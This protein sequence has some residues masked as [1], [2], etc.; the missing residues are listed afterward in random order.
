MKVVVAIDS[1]KGSLSSLQAGNAIKEG[2]LR[3][4]ESHV[5]VKPLA[6]GG[7]GTME[8]LIDGLGGEYISLEVLDQMGDPMV[9]TYG[10]LKD[11]NT[12]I[13]EMAR[14]VG[15]TLINEQTRNP[16]LA[17]TYAVGQLI[18]DAI[19]KGCLNFII[20]IGGSATNDGGIG[21]LSALGVIFSDKN[22]K[23]LECTPM[24]LGSIQS[25]DTTKMH[26]E[27]SNCKFLVACDVNNP[28]CGE[29]GATYI[30]GPQKGVKID[31]L[32]KLDANMLHYATITSD[33]L[34][35][36]HINSSGSG[37]AG[38]I[39]FALLSYLDATIKSGAEVVIDAL[40]LEKDIKTADI[41][42]TGEGRLDYQTAMGKGPIS[43]A[44]ISKKYNKPVIA[45]AGSIS[46]T[47]NVCNQSGIDSYFSIL[48][49]VT[50][51]KDAMSIEIATKNM[52]D[53]T[54]QIFRLIKSLGYGGKH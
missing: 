47:A 34:G 33:T 6:D 23:Y 24:S 27:I 52:I 53:S 10:I 13:I 22:G 39:G 21:M 42:I 8:T 40:D 7:E 28:L 9:G 18:L 25:I 15:I 31:E 11:S 14:V 3:A 49:T 4:I 20:C 30:Y 2:I 5:I 37:A 46:E 50:T 1:F 19:N 43:V 51:L 48:N 29:N 35:N 36:C 38:G 45:L 17:N 26:K 32:K 44:N 54:E 41:V 16:L 12:A